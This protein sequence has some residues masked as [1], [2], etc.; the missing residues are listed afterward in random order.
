MSKVKVFKFPKK[1]VEVEEKEFLDELAKKMVKAILCLQET[2]KILADRILVFNEII[3]S[4]SADLEKW[5]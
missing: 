2:N 3:E 4:I 1:M 5:K